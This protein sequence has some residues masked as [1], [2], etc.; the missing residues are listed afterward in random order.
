MNFLLGGAGRLVTGPLK[1]GL[2]GGIAVMFAFALFYVL[3]FST[4]GESRPGAPIFWPDHPFNV[5]TAEVAERF[6]GVDNF[7]VFV[8][9]DQKGASADGAVLQR[10]EGL[11]RH[12]RKYADPGAALSLVTIIRIFWQ[13]N[14]YGDPKWGFVPDSAEAVARIVF[15]LM[16]SSTPGALRPFLTDEQEDA[17]VNFFFRDHKGTTILKAV[18]YAE[19]YIRDNPMG[20]LSVRLEEDPSGVKDFFYYMFGPLLPPRSESMQVRIAE[21]DEQ[22]VITGYHEGETHEVG[23]WSEPADPAEVEANVVDALVKLGGRTAGKMRDQM[24]LD[25]LIHEELE[26]RDDQLEK[27]LLKLSQEWDYRVEG[28]TESYRDVASQV[29]TI[30]DVVDRIVER[31]QFEV[32]EEWKNPDMGITAQKIRFCATYCPYEL[33]VQ[34]AKFRDSSFNPQPTGSWTR[35]AEFILAGGIMGTFAA[36]N[37]EVER[38]HVAN[39]LLIFLIV[40]TFV[41]VSYRSAMGGAIIMFSLATGTVMSLFYMA[42]RETGLNINTLPVQGV[43]VGIGVDYAIYITDRIRQEYSWCGDLDEG[44]RRAIRTTGMAVAFTATTLVGGIGAW[45]LSNLRFQAE[46]AQL[47]SILMVVN[48]LGGIV[49]VPALFSIFRPK[50]FS[51]SLSEETARTGE[52]ATSAAAGGGS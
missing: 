18:H 23:E 3:N 44:I 25:S 41:S 1:Y 36:V 28:V 2:V 30:G 14:H 26:V 19:E 38:S 12:V 16:R 45:V 9:G 32:L 37:E 27:V 10:M 48:M 20:R 13:T 24:T 4:I 34:N 8:D 22:R 47:L 35:G 7:T 17:N 46:M 40:F 52:P 43:G 50:F 5:A 11:E 6:G 33:W 29:V 15:Q 49:L 51:S 42:L 39:I 31:S 21:I